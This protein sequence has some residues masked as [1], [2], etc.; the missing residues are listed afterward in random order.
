MSNYWRQWVCLWGT[1]SYPLIKACVCVYLFI[2]RC[3]S[4]Y[5]PSGSKT[6]VLSPHGGSYCKLLL[7]FQSC[8]QKWISVFSKK[9]P[10][11]I[12]TL[13]L[14]CQYFFLIIISICCWG[15]S[16]MNSRRSIALFLS[17]SFLL[18]ATV[19]LIL[20][21]LMCSYNRRF[22]T[23]IYF[24]YTASWTTLNVDWSKSGTN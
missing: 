16:V 2:S 23:S 17:L 14:E 9:K 20:I 15:N 12:L 4:R 7:H 1:P 18:L 21:L 6:W 11:N 24:H 3:Y 5:S 19:N 8:C 22:L 13:F 10:K